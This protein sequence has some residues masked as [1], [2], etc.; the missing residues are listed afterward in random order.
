[1]SLSVWAFT[2]IT[3][4]RSSYR[5][6]FIVY[7]HI[8]LME[9]FALSLF[10]KVTTSDLLTA[11][12]VL[13]LS[14]WNVHFRREKLRDDPSGKTKNLF[15]EFHQMF[16]VMVKYDLNVSFVIL[17]REH[18]R[19][20]ANKKL[21]IQNRLAL[22]VAIKFKVYFNERSLILRDL[23]TDWPGLALAQDTGNMT[24]AVNWPL[25]TC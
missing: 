16:F 17:I 10:P 12:R 19:C 24:P 18:F 5:M 15:Y 20:Q 3:Q 7:C 14:S 2:E 23:R 22:E 8:A 25:V 6:V 21:N 13:S 1:M 4:S 11:S 9:I